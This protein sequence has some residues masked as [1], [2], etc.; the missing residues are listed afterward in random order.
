MFCGQGWLRIESMRNWQKKLM[1]MSLG[2]VLMLGA[3]LHGR[4][5]ERWTALA[6]IESGNNDHA[7][8]LAGEVSRYQI[9]PR[10]WHRYASANANWRNAEQSLPIAKAAMQDRCAAF[11]RSFRRPPTDFE[12]YVLWN[13]PGQIRRPSQAVSKRAQRFCNLVNSDLSNASAL[14]DLTSLPQ[15]DAIRGQ[16]NGSKPPEL[17]ITSK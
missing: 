11:Q 9:K 16:G 12:F 10:V 1:I 2:V 8:G 15:V 4:A 3:S 5:M 7:L 14:T 6:Q 17:K 13:A